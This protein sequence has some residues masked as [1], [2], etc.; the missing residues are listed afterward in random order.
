M[1]AEIIVS[2]LALA[3]TGI[4]GFMQYRSASRKAHAESNAVDVK[5]FKELV[6]EVMAIKTGMLK[7]ERKYQITLTYVYELLDFI[8][9]GGLT[10][11]VPPIEMVDDENIKKITERW[12]HVTKT[13]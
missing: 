4:L 7:C 8:Y 13:K 12:T 1:S 3:S 10:P 2:F 6:D 5:T 9:Q 11:P